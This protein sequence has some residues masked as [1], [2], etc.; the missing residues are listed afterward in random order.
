LN[1]TTDTYSELQHAYDYL[2]EH[3]FDDRLPKCLITL[4]RQHDTFGYFSAN[5]FV[6]LGGQADFTHEIALNPIYFAVRSIPETLSVMARE[7]V[8]LDLLLHSTGKPPRRRYRNKE[9]AEACEDI[10]IMPTDTGEPGG[11]KVGDNIQTYIIEGG[12]FDLVSAQ[13]C[14][15]EFRLSWVDRFPPQMSQHEEVLNLDA[16]RNATSPTH[17]ADVAPGNDD[18]ADL[19]ARVEDGGNTGN[20]LLDVIGDDDLPNGHATPAGKSDAQSSSSEPPVKPPQ[21]DEAPRMKVFAHARS[22]QLADMGIEPKAKAKN[23]SKTKFKCPVCPANAWGKPSLLL[24]CKGS[25]RKPHDVTDMVLV[26]TPQV[27][28]DL[29]TVDT[30]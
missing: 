4:Q 17:A 22:E 28:E 23:A 10:G 26:G 25:E 21:Y 9:W 18:L 5:Q 12:K 20:S 19:I 3:L 8:T 7:M 15:T 30:F 27:E 29:E 11:K 16:G 14:D 2:N 13:L 1:P 24:A 6:K